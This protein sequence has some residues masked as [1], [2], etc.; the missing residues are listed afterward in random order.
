MD[1]Q[2][3]GLRSSELQANAYLTKP[4]DPAEFIE[5]VR[6]F[7]EFWLSVVRFPPDDDAEE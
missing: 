6:S 4:V 1:A 5:T 2:E 7:R 3:D